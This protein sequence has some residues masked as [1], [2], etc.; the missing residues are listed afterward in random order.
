MKQHRIIVRLAE[1]ARAFELE[2]AA[3]IGTPTIGPFER[4]L[5]VAGVEALSSVVFNTASHVVL[6][7]NLVEAN[8]EILTANRIGSFIE[9]VRTQ[10]QD[11]TQNPAWAA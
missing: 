7:A 5:A 8:G 2:I 1:E 11:P 6:V 4:A 9:A 3:P 10:L